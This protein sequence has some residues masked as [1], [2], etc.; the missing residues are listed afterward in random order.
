[1]IHNKA[2]LQRQN[3]ISKNTKKYKGIVNKV[4]DLM[5][6][7]GTN[8]FILGQGNAYYNPENKTKDP[9]AILATGASS[10][11]VE[12]FNSPI[13]YE[14]SLP[15]LNYIIREYHINV[16]SGN[17]RKRFVNFLQKIQDLHDV[18]SPDIFSTGFNLSK[19]VAGMNELKETL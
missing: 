11:W 17:E 14:S 19:F 2:Y 10:G 15:L 7:Q 4:I 5:K 9:V 8:C 1:M 3:T 16:D 6:K 13:E 18:D 12:M